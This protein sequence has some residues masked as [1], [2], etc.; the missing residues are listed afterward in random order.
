MPLFL[1]TVYEKREQAR[2]EW[3]AGISHD[4][5]TPLAVVMGYSDTLE[6]SEGLPEEIRQQAAVIR[7]QS[8]V[9]KS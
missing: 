6:H 8:V 3:I 2:I 7:H 9:M 5:R 4:I 1:Q